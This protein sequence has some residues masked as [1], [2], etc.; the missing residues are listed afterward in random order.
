MTQLKHSEMRQPDR[1]HHN[2]HPVDH[3]QHLIHTTPRNTTRPEPYRTHQHLALAERI[4]PARKTIA[5]LARTHHPY[6]NHIPNRYYRH[7]QRSF[8]PDAAFQHLF[9][10]TLHAVPPDHPDSIALDST[11]VPRTGNYIP[12]AHW[13]P[14]PTNAPFA[15]GLRKAQRFVRAGWL[16]NDPNARCV[17]LYWLPTFAHKAR[18]ANPASHRSE[19]E[20]WMA[21]IQRVRAW[22]NAAE[23]AEQ[24]LLCVGDGRGDTQAL[25]TLDLPNTVCLVRTRQDSRGCD[26]PQGA[27]LGRGRRR[28]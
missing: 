28:V 7:Y 20:G 26:L 5:Q 11:T 21:S 23:R 9:R 22:L 14:N 8:N 27:P 4:T 18:Y 2:T 1:Q 6:P 3:C 19:I 16:D 25:G 17:P 24:R 15:C 13:T 12:D 10:N